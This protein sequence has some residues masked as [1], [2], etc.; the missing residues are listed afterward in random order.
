MW[1]ITAELAATEY[2]SCVDFNGFKKQFIY[3]QRRNPA[4]GK[5]GPCEPG[6]SW[7]GDYEVWENAE[8]VI[9][10]PCSF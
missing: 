1:S 3:S 7:A 4:A 5:L 8:T 6:N 9:C 10:L 2:Y